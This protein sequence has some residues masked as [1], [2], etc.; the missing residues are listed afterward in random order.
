MALQ[1]LYRKVTNPHA[2]FQTFVIKLVAYRSLNTVC[3][4]TIDIDRKSSCRQKTFERHVKPPTV[5]GCYILR[6][7]S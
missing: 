5:W 1:E 2:R 6:F 3:I 4:A 7:T